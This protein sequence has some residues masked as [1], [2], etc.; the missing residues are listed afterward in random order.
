M[1]GVGEECPF[2]KKVVGAKPGQG[3]RDRVESEGQG[4]L[5]GPGGSGSKSKGDSLPVS[6]G[7]K[8]P[9][10]A[11]RMENSRRVQE[12]AKAAFTE[13]VKRVGLFLKWITKD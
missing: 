6:K 9:A 10:S 4:A 7:D 12:F 8:L 13:D 2:A 1:D 11:M 5:H 3:E